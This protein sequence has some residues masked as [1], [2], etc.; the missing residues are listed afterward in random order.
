MDWI[1]HGTI[2]RPGRGEPGGAPEASF[3][4]TGLARSGTSML[5]RVMQAGGVFIGTEIDDVVYEDVEIGHALEAGDATGL[6]ALVA[7]RDEAH[8]VWG[9]KRPHLHAVMRPE[10]ILG[11]RA[12]RLLVVFRDPIAIA[13]RNVISELLPERQAVEEAA[14]AQKAL[15][16]F[17]YAAECP[18]LLV[19]Y[20]KAVT[21]PEQFVDEIIRFCGIA[22]MAARREAMIAAVDPNRADYLHGARRHYEGVIDQITDGVLTGWAW[23]IGEASPVR[24]ALFIDK[25]MVAT[26]SADVWRPDLQEAGIGTGQHGFAVDV[27]ALLHRRDAVIEVFVEGRRFSLTHGGAT[28]AE[29]DKSPNSLLA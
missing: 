26:F 22:G 20:E 4:I 13:Q 21:M 2:A 5:A 28:I 6:A 23:Q 7:A 3:V 14:S 27:A 29:L 9:F 16:D 11:L 17:V 1:N 18:A 8:A 25:E 19:S 10:A 24:L 12:P 15:I